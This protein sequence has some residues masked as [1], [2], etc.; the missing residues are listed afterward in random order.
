MISFDI[1]SVSKNALSDLINIAYHKIFYGIN[2][3]LWWKIL[4]YTIYLAIG[5]EKENKK[6]QEFSLE[7]LEK[8]VD[9]LEVSV[10]KQFD[11]YSNFRI[12]FV[13]YRY[14]YMPLLFHNDS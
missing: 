7:N 4:L 1:Y 11:T 10:L 2:F 3:K 12:N 13:D 9:Y 6:L 8:N 14:F 5:L